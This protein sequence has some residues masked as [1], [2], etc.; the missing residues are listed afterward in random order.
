MIS[1]VGLGQPMRGDDSVGYLVLQGLRE[2]SGLKKLWVGDDMTR[3]LDVMTGEALVI[4]VDAVRSGAPV[5]TV[6]K[7]ELEDL[8]AVKE[9]R[10]STH[11]LGPREVFGLARALGRPFPERLLLL[12][13]EGQDFA[14]GSPLSPSVAA[15]LPELEAL[16]ERELAS[17]QPG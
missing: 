8:E 14:L 2:R 15:A 12:G 7:L 6:H 13:V 4:L 16:L 9:W 3:I 17:L 11:G 5:G 10:C 1:V